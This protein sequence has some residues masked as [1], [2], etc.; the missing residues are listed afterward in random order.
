MIIMSKPPFHRSLFIVMVV[1]FI[2][3]YSYG[4]ELKLSDSIKTFDNHVKLLTPFPD[5]VRITGYGAALQWPVS[6]RN[7]LPLTYKYKPICYPD[8]YVDKSPL[9]RGDYCVSSAM[10]DF[11]RETVYG[12]GQRSTLIG[13]G[14][15]NYAGVG[16]MRYYNDRFLA[17]V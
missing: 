3:R 14:I 15:M 1:I 9:H 11:C 17:D 8:F 7:I 5:F 12:F 2:V 6:D 10:N 13:I 16:Y 4:Q